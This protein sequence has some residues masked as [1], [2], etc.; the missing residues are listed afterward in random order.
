M[1]RKPEIN[2]KQFMALHELSKALRK[3]SE[4]CEEENGDFF[5]D[6][7]LAGKLGRC[8]GMSIDEMSGEIDAFLDEMIDI[9]NGR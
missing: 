5:N 1:A 3:V 2:N 7:I 9:W 4:L 8:W 6:E